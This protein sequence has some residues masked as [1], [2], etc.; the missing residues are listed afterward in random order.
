LS[1]ETET[2]WRYSGTG[3][4]ESPTGPDAYYSDLAGTRFTQGMDLAQVTE[5]YRIMRDLEGIQDPSDFIERNR[6]TRRA[7]AVLNGAFNGASLAGWFTSGPGEVS[8][9]SDGGP[10]PTFATR[11]TTGSPVTLGQLVRTPDEPF[12]VRFSYRFETVTGQLE[13][14]LGDAHLGTLDAPNPALGQGQE[15]VFEV[16]DPDYIG[17]ELP[18]EFRLDGPTG[19]SL[20]LDDVSVT[21]LGLETRLGAN[22]HRTISYTDTNGAEVTLRLTRGSAAIR[23][24]GTPVTRE[25]R[26]GIVITGVSRLAEVQVL[27]SDADSTLSIA[28]EGGE[29]YAQVGSIVVSGVLRSLV[30]KRVELTGA[31]SFGGAVRRVGLAALSGTVSIG[32]DAASAPV[33][34]ELGEV[35]NASLTSLAAIKSLTATEWKD[36]DDT[37]DVIETP[38]IGTVTIKGERQ[39]EIRGDFEAGIVTTDAAV[40]LTK[41]WVAGLLRDARIQTAGSLVSVTVGALEG[42][43]LFAG[44]NGDAFPDDAVDFNEFS[45]GSV[46]VK[47]TTGL[48]GSSFVGSSLAAASIGNVKLRD[49]DGD[50][51]GEAFGLAAKRIGSVRIGDAKLPPPLVD[52]DLDDDFVIR[53]V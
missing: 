25:V 31:L 44:V 18:I 21:P 42:A 13:V 47:G 37:A 15:I 32:G 34:L 50:N 24:T 45:I 33:R 49:V 11:L 43:K 48:Q 39:R 19:S 10:T 22:G 12:G 46:T 40:E 9:V 8:V 26:G 4:G 29:D 52:P 5:A 3:G 7:S 53:L 23:F 35:R 36:D 38:W 27:T 16:T 2:L 51:G 17:N 6:P 41:F 30:A 20:L 28:A 1:S 14:W